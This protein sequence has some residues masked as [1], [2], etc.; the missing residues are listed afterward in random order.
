M[1]M[2]TSKGKLNLYFIKIK[3]Y[4]QALKFDSITL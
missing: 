4:L 3:Q 1:Q 2:Q